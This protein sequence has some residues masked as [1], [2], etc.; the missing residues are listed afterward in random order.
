MKK[1]LEFIETFLEPWEQI[2]ECWEYTSFFRLSQLRDEKNKDLKVADY[3]NKY[4]VLK[5]PAGH[6][7][8]GIFF[9]IVILQ[10]VHC[11]KVINFIFVICIFFQQ[12]EYDFQVLFNEAENRMLTYWP[13]F[14]AKIKHELINIGVQEESLG[15]KVIFS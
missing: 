7:L 12:L 13:Q 2:K 9:F 11:F 5:Q 10:N 14:S 15:Q 4:P 1:C 3:I 8:V 6:L